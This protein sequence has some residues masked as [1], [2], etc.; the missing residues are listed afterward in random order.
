MCPA[1]DSHLTL[2]FHDHFVMRP[3]IIFTESGNDYAL[4]GVG[5][6]GQPVPRE[7]EYHSGRNERFLTVP[8]IVQFNQRAE[9]E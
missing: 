6:Q 3:G 1:D 5:E 7:F 2:E 4:N 9:A 8:E